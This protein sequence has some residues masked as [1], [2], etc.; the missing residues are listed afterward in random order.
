MTTD[1]AWQNHKYQTLQRI[2]KYVENVTRQSR[3]LYVNNDVELALYASDIFQPET[4]IDKA[5]KYEVS[6]LW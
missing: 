3:I 6:L 4:W 1:D 5:G 2:T